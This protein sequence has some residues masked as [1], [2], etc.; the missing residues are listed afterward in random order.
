M[1]QF[2]PL[3]LGRCQ[4]GTAMSKLTR[5]GWLKVPSLA[6][7]CAVT[8][9]PQRPARSLRAPETRDKSPRRLDAE[10]RWRWRS[11]AC[12]TS[13]SRRLS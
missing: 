6:A 5:R 1:N 7:A 3:F 12:P 4:E 2:K 13:R 10:E 9:R 11:V 8:Y